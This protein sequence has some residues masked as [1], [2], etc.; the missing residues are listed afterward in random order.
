[1]ATQDD[2]SEY[3]IAPDLS[4]RGLSRAV[5]GIDQDGNEIKEKHQST[6]GRFILANLLPKNKNIKFNLIN[7]VFI[8][9]TDSVHI[10]ETYFEYLSNNIHVVTCNKIAC[11]S[12]YKYYEKLKNQSRFGKSKFLYETS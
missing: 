8:D 3:L 2:Q 10:A 9:N 4:R 6:A 12:D 11:S 1:M 5:D 7:S